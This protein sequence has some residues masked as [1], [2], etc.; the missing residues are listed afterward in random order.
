MGQRLPAIRV[1]RS[2]L[3]TPINVQS[4]PFIDSHRP[5]DL[6]RSFQKLLS[7]YR[8]RVFPAE[9]SKGVLRL[10]GVGRVY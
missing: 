6:A 10:L 8:F 7:L 3:L 2:R 4:C 9:G 1:D 5:P